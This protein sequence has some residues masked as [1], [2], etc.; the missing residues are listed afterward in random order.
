MKRTSDSENDT[1]M[2]GE[3]ELDYSRAKPNRFAQKKS[4]VMVALYPDV[5]EVFSTSEAV[6][7]ALRAIISAMPH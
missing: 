6:N 5:A 3:Y 7:K 2:L 4:Q 1:D